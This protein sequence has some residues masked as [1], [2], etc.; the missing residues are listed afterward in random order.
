MKIRSGDKVV[1]TAGKDKGKEGK[2]LAVDTKNSRV[3]IEGI[4]IVTKH[5]KKQG[6]TPGQIIKVEKSIDVSNVSLK[7]PTTGKPTR[8]GVKIEG[9]KKTRVSKKS[10][11]A[12]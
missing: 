9:G 12:I 1:V 6:A 2:I 11:K 8:I 3:V 7:C 5:I 10:G 4:N